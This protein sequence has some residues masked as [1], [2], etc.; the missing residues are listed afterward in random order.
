VTPLPSVWLRIE[1]LG[2]E[3]VPVRWEATA[4]NADKRLSGSLSLPITPPPTTAAELME[5]LPEDD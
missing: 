1:D 4:T 2:I 3:T 5:D